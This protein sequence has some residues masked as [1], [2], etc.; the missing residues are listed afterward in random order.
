MKV[1]GLLESEK[2]MLTPNKVSEKLL[3]SKCMQITQMQ[4]KKHP[5]RTFTF[6]DT[7]VNQ[8]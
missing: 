2:S 5:G 7:K 6:P 1:G 8:A 3:G 4:G